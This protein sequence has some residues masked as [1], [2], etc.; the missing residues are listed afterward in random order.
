LYFRLGGFLNAK[1]GVDY[2]HWKEAQPAT[3]GIGTFGIGTF[4]IENKA[5]THGIEDSRHTDDSFEYFRVVV[6][7]GRIFHNSAQKLYLDAS[8]YTAQDRNGSPK[9]NFHS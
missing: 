3:K 8:K 6:G 5:K 9:R 7:S 1:C 2:R 4:G